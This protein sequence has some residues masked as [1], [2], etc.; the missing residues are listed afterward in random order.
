M[1][2]PSKKE[3]TK[4]LLITYILNFIGFVGIIINDINFQSVFRD[5]T[6][7]TGLFILGTLVPGLIGLYFVYKKNKDAFKTENFNPIS[8]LFMLFFLLVHVTLY[9]LMGDLNKVKLGGNLLFRIILMILLFGIQEFSWIDIVYDYYVDEKGI[10][11]SMI[12]VG[13]YK[14]IGF[15]P[16]TLLPGFLVGAHSYAPFATLLVGISAMSIY[17]KKISRSFYMSALFVGLIY[18]IMSYTDLNQGMIMFLIMF[19]ECI[20]VYALEGFVKKD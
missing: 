1:R 13:L 10:Y 11:K 12:I 14:A 19:I 16:L 18:A 20:I 2:K 8:I 7:G 15:L 6:L 4:F 17:L 3:L 5:S 9:N